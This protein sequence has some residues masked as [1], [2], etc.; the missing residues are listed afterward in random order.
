MRTV[1]AAAV[2]LSCLSLSLAARSADDP[3]EEVKRVS[4]AIEKSVGWYDVF[5]D[6]TSTAP[7]PV[8]V[9]QRWRNV[10]RG[11]Q[12]EALLAVWH[13]NG[14]PVAMASVYPWQGKMNHEFDSLSRGNKL[15]ARDKKEAV[16]WSPESPGVEFKPVPGVPKPG[17]TAN[18]RLLQMKA[19][20]ER[21]TAT[22]T[23]WAGDNSDKEVL[24]LMTKEL[25]R[26][27]LADAKEPDPMLLDGA[28]F[29][30]AQGNDPEVVL[31]LEAV[32]PA[33]SAAWHY[34]FARATSGG[35]EVKLGGAVV[36]TA[37]KGPK[38]RVPTLPHFTAQRPLEP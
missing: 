6:S 30:Y 17:K 27:K 33:E 16:V 37:E 5:P 23:G 10:V 34:A 36:W 28:M 3:P 31:L 24:R 1:R 26:Y 8:A 19:I 2:L 29:A 15:V 9:V 21:F 12:G 32:G 25:Y 4:E 35:L 14:R 13:H 7:L 22:M 38:A 18:V 11:Q 20:A